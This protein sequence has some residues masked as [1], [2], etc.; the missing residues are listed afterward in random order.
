MSENYI[1]WPTDTESL[2]VHN[3]SLGTENT[4]IATKKSDLIFFSERMIPSRSNI[5]TSQLRKFL[6]LCVY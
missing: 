3:T 1:V 5:S 2:R 6:V 4:T